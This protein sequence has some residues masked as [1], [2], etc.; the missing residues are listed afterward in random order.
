[1]HLWLVVVVEWFDVMVDKINSCWGGGGGRY[2]VRFKSICFDVGS[3][4]R[5]HGLQISVECFKNYAM[6]HGC[7]QPYSRR[8]ARKSRE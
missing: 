4:S 7:I 1:M 3:C 5:L 8:L 2:L 6:Q